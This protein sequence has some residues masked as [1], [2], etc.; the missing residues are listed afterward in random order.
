[1][2]NISQY[3]GIPYASK[4]RTFLGCDC[5]GLLYLLYKFEKDILLE[6]F[7]ETYVDAKNLES[8]CGAVIQNRHDWVKIEDAE[9][10]EFDVILLKIKGYAAH[11]GV[12][13]DSNRKDFIHTLA[14]HDSALDNYG[15]LAWKKRIEGFYRHKT[16]K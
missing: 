2:K 12:V 11:V 14:G 13:L 15:R 8:V 5:Y 9:V 6:L 16:L 3:I 4:G 10:Q 7:G 1:M